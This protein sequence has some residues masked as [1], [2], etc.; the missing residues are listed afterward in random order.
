MSLTVESLLVDQFLGYLYSVG[1]L[2]SVNNGPLCLWLCFG[3]ET[4]TDTNQGS[5]VSSSVAQ[6]IPLLWRIFSSFV[7]CSTDKHGVAQSLFHSEYPLGGNATKTT[8]GV[9]D[10]YPSVPG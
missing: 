10:T 8:G 9:G 2:P 1:Y 6:L 5:A 7:S 4:I 3:L